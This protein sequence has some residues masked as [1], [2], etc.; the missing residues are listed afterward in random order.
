VDDEI[1][2]EVAVLCGCGG[3][4]RVGGVEVAPERREGPST[5]AYQR[6]SLSTAC[7]RWRRSMRST[8][9]NFDPRR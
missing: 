8:T 9:T 1:G 5:V 3:L 4:E 6:L 2:D 7:L